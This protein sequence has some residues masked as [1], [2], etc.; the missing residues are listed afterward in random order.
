MSFKNISSEEYDRSIRNK[1]RIFDMTFKTPEVLNKYRVDKNIYNEIKQ[2]ERL[3]NYDKIFHENLDKYFIENKDEK[4]IEEVSRYNYNI[5]KNKEKDN[6][7]FINQNI[8]LTNMI[9]YNFFPNINEKFKLTVKYNNSNLE[10]NFQE[11][12]YNIDDISNIINLK[13]KEISNIDIEE[14]IKLVVD[15]N[16]YKILVI[17]QEN[18]KLILDKNFMKLLGFSKYVINPGYNRSDLIPQ[19]D[20]AKYLK[21]YCNIV[22]NKTENEF[23]SNVF[24]K[25]GIGDLVAYDNFNIYKNQKF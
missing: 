6:T 22:N 2:N 25:N 11:G 23:L 19:S 14:P 4:K 10:I 13:I 18:F 1:N 24:I 5:I 21:I 16:Q 7:R 15:I 20:K 17:V 9:S 12:A 8:S 3:E